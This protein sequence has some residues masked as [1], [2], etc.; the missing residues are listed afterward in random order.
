MKNYV[1]SFKKIGVKLAMQNVLEL[2]FTLEIL[3]N[4]GFIM[5][6]LKIIKIFQCA[7]KLKLPKI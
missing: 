1:Q 4:M 7:I 2:S 5:Q 3:Q 6:T